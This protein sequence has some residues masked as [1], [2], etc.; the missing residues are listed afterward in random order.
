MKLYNSKCWLTDLPKSAFSLFNFTGNFCLWY[1]IQQTHI[2]QTLQKYKVRSSTIAIFNMYFKNEHSIWLLTSNSFG[3]NYPLKIYILH[4]KKC[5]LLWLPARNVV[6]VDLSSANS[7]VNPP[8]MPS[9]SGSEASVTSSLSSSLSSSL[10]SSVALSSDCSA[11]SK[12][13]NNI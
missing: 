10:A 12:L 5:D 11:S 6:D 2:T 4:R 1:C 9:S 13:Q 3:G 8:S 7:S